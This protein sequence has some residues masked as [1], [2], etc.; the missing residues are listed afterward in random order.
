[1]YYAHST[2]NPD[3]SDWQSLVGH[4]KKV[5]EL[6]AERGDKFGAARATELAGWLRDLGKYGVNSRRK[7]LA[8]IWHF[9]SGVQTRRLS[10]PR[11]LR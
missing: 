8:T 5:A 6:A 7:L 3:R 10:L 4:L 2:G 9:C 1:M 11:R